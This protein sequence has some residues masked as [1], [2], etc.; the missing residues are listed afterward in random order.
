MAGP[1]RSNSSAS[2]TLSVSLNTWRNGPDITSTSAYATV[3]WS[4]TLG[5]ATSL[6][7]GSNR[8]LYVYRSDGALLGSAVIK[9][10]I[11]WNSSAT[12]SG[13]F[14]IGF[15]SGTYNSF[16]WDLYIQTSSE[17][18]QSCIWTNRSYCTDFSVSWPL[19]WSYAT[20]P[21]SLSLSP[22]VFENTVR[23][24]WSGAASGINNGI[25]TYHC[26]YQY[27]DNSGGSWSE[28]TIVNSGGAG[29]IDVDTASWPRG[30]LIRFHVYSISTYNDPLSG[31][32]GTARKNRPPNAPT[33]TPTTNRSVYSPGET[34]VLTFEPP[35]PRDP[36]TGTSGDIA[37]YEVK[38][39]HPDGSDYSFE[40]IMGAN[41]SP[42]ATSVNVSTVE[43]T[44]GQQ[45]TLHVRGY[46][47][48]GVRS[49]WSA[50][51]A[52]IT[53]G[54]PL[55]VLVSGSLKSVAEQRV[56]VNG[57][58]KQVSEVKVLVDGTLKNLTI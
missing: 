26:Y 55:R 6:G 17:G 28:K 57:V 38:L 41:P 56:L 54:T 3:N 12:Y 29:Y 32:S 25:S 22:G 30:R 19:Y 31:Y 1:F 51:T 34:I 46:D 2:T 10:G 58:L 23:L 49:E 14:N 53:I 16:A 27:S 40:R 18:T 50:A 42:T 43:W 44:P 35:E 33:G 11:A 36:D 15:D 39:K 47:L 5:S 21:T 4:V 8:T 48:L 52:L 7:S 45:W 13:S 37:G 9:N 24:S 20:A